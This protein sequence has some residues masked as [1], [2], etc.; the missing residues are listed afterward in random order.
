M[1]GSLFVSGADWLFLASLTIHLFVIPHIHHWS[2]VPIF[3]TYHMQSEHFI[4]VGKWCPKSKIG[5]SVTH[6]LVVHHCSQ[7]RTTPMRGICALSYP[8]HTV[9]I[10]ALESD[11]NV[12]FVLWNNKNC[13][14]D[15]R[16][17]QRCF[18]SDTFLLMLEWKTD[19]PTWK[20][21]EI[22]NN[23]RGPRPIRTA[24]LP[25][26]QKDWLRVNMAT[27]LMQCAKM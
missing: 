18:T 16:Y 7:L 12:G 8:V 20:Q 19:Q 15:C 26:Q 25:M 22:R 11:K 14:H 24:N 13:A 10:L 9:L 23:A 21:P 5:V 17:E 6:G 27:D 4:P 3:E 2:V 1:Y